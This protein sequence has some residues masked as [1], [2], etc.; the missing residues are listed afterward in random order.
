MVARPI[1]IPLQHL[2][3]G[4]TERNFEFL[5][6]E[7]GN[8]QT[9]GAEPG[10]HF[11]ERII[12]N[13]VLDLNLPTNSPPPSDPCG[14]R[15]CRR[16]SDARPD[17]LGTRTYC[18]RSLRWTDAQLLDDCPGP[19][20]RDFPAGF[21]RP[22]PYD[23]AHLAV[24]PGPG[25]GVGAAFRDRRRR[26]SPAAHPGRSPGN[27]NRPSCGGRFNGRGPAGSPPV[28]AAAASDRAHLP[29]GS[30]AQHTETVFS[31]IFRA[32][33]APNCRMRR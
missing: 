18:L 26:V 4:G 31:G 23:P 5:R 33:P 14:Q 10:D 24:G 20:R 29:P 17:S 11:P 15:D 30:T 22:R 21:G 2:T 27:R 25:Q 16:G 12:P 7:R 32:V 19:T 8:E 28:R 9:E 6:K 3:R 1:G 13:R